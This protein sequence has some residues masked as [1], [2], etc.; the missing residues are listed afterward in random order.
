[1]HSAS[2]RGIMAGID[3]EHQADSRNINRYKAYPLVQ[4]KLGL[5]F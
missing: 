5:R 3:A 2:C 4:F 1:L